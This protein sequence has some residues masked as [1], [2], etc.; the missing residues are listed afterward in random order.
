MSLFPDIR[1]NADLVKQFHESFGVPGLAEPGFPDDDRITL[2]L[3]LI[4][5]EFGELQ[6]ALARAVE[7]RDIIEVADA[8][9]D[10][11]VVTYG[12]A[13]EFGIPIDEVF[14]EVHASNMSKLGADG[15]PIYREDGKVLKGPNFRPPDIKGVL[16]GQGEAPDEQA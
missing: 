16:Y 9:A 8:I 7:E 13:H 14:E 10:L 15:R 6:V 4:D 2:R 1:S 5:E 3:K 12:T 11:L